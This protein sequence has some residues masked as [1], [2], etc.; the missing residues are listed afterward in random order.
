MSFCN[1]D[2]LIRNINTLMKN[3]GITQ[4]KL[5]E[6]LG[7]SQPNVSKALSPTD[8][9]CF[10]LD[11]VVGIAKHFGVSIDQLV[12]N[13]STSSRATG[14]RAVA[15]FLTKVIE[16]HDARYTKV[17]I[18]E[19]VYELHE[20]HDVFTDSY[21][22]DTDIVDKNISY[23]ALYFP[24]YWKVPSP[25]DG[26]DNAALELVSEAKACGNE[27]VMKPVNDYLRKFI[28]I[29]EIYENHGID[30]DAYRV[31]VDNYLSKIPDPFLPS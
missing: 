4:A 27:S 30:E 7:M 21:G 28:Q 1:T 16:S 5:A 14:P 29:F 10:T 17:N 20:I 23:F 11:Q 18:S 3:N 12:G 31:V 13:K 6:I 2:V 25:K 19:E 15:E 26:Y 9:K 24:D 8:K 22:I